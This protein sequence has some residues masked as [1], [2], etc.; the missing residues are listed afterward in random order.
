MTYEEY[1]TTLNMLRATN[2]MSAVQDLKHD[3][4]ANVI[5]EYSGKCNRT[6][7]SLLKSARLYILKALEYAV[8]QSESGNSIVYTTNY[9]LADKIGQIIWQEIGDYLLDFQIYDEGN[10]TAI[11]CMFGGNFVINWDEDCE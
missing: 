3:Y 2:R 11:D 1:C 5:N 10:S 6:G 8:Y 4:M 7:D 9:V